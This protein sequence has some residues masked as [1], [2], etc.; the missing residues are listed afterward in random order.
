MSVIPSIVLILLFLV[1]LYAHYRISRRMGFG[2]GMS[3]LI[4]VSAI[5]GLPIILWWC[6]DWPNERGPGGPEIFE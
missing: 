2:G 5:F 3:I 6:L 4:A 1:Y